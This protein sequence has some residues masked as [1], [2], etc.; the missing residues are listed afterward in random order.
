[1]RAWKCQWIVGLLLPCLP[2]LAE[3]RVVAPIPQPRAELGI[4]QTS[5]GGWLVLGSPGE[6][7]DKGAVQ[8]YQC[9][10][11]PCAATQRLAPAELLPADRFGLGVAM[12]ATR[13]AVAA[14]GRQGGAVYLH[15]LD[16]GTWTFQQRL[17]APAPGNEGFG[18]ALA[19]AGSRLFVGAPAAD[20][21]AGA[22]Y[23]YT[24]QAGSWTLQ[25][26]LD[27]DD[28]QAGA[29]FGAALASDGATLL[30]A[31]RQRPMVCRAAMRRARPTCWM[32]MP[33]MHSWLGWLIRAPHRA[34]V[35][36]VQWP[37]MERAR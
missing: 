32:A 23:V 17:D 12:S 29:G 20:L 5:A 7:S 27:A 13:L 36:A 16:A 1:M 11:E 19:L 2:G 14:P 9:A 31:H 22:V 26:R 34:H 33:R 28:V 15:T 25:A 24:E 30:S 4:S 18:S 35:S 6:E 10:G 21:G 3:A 37:L 8:L